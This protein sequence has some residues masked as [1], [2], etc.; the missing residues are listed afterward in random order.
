MRAPLSWIREFAPVDAAPPAMRTAPPCDRRVPSVRSASPPGRP[1]GRLGRRDPL[2]EE[3]FEDP[4]PE[5][6]LE[7]VRAHRST[8]LFVNSRRLAER[9]ATALNELAGEEIARAHHGSMSREARTQVEDYLKAGR[10]PAVVAT[11]SLELGID[12]GTIDVVVQIG[13]RLTVYDPSPW[14][15]P[16]WWRWG[17]RYWRGPVL[18]QFDGRSWRTAPRGGSSPFVGSTGAKV[19]Y[20]LPALLAKLVHGGRGG[21]CFEQG[22]LLLHMLRALGF[23][24]V[25]LIVG[26]ARWSSSQALATVPCLATDQKYSR[27]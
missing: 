23:I 15:D 20:T 1:I 8:I 25:P 22:Y 27:W 18:S 21:Y 24:A 5:A 26:W 16:L 14:A 4:R 11:S 3:P 6:L 12:M 7:L 13:V 2:V 17:N 10:L 9:L 19:D